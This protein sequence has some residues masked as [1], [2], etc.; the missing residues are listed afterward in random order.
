MVAFICVQKICAGEVLHILIIKE[1]RI[2]FMANVNY[3]TI[4]NLDALELSNW[5]DSEFGVQTPT[6]IISVEDMNEASKLLL[7][8][9]SYYS[10]L[11]SLLARAEIATRNAKRNSSKNEYEDMVDRKK[12]ISL[13][14]D[15]V[16]QQYSAISRAV[17]IHIENNQE[18]R[19][20][21][22]GKI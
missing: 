1:G 21:S 12:A 19:F 18:L 22:S 8:L 5:L 10:Y 17:T 4:L 2:I 20:G 16:K 11:C 6:E 14:V 9:S 7:K 15:R 13:A 3:N